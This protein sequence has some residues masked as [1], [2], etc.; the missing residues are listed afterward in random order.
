MSGSVL[1]WPGDIVIC[2]YQTHIEEKKEYVDT[3]VIPASHSSYNATRCFYI[4]LHFSLAP[5]HLRALGWC[6]IGAGLAATYGTKRFVNMCNKIE[7][8]TRA[9]RLEAII[10]KYC[11]S[12]KGVHA[13]I[14]V[15]FAPPFCA[16]LPFAHSAITQ[17]CKQQDFRKS[18]C[19]YCT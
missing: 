9:G 13:W 4:L 11:A 12:R 10:S 2:P 15:T 8:S 18:W 19:G 6:N 16:P 14:S 7:R 5:T 3:I 1:L 17:I